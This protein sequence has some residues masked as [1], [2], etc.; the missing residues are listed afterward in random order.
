MFGKLIP[1]SFCTSWDSLLIF[2][3]KGGWVRQFGVKEESGV[4]WQPG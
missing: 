4:N 2:S 1:A 3:G